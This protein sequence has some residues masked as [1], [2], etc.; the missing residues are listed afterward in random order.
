[1]EIQFSYSQ[2]HLVVIPL[3]QYLNALRFM[4]HIIILH[5]L[6]HCTTKRVLFTFYSFMFLKILSFHFVVSCFIYFFVYAYKTIIIIMKMS[7]MNPHNSMLEIIKNKIYFFSLL[8]SIWLNI[9]SSHKTLW[10]RATRKEL[11]CRSVLHKHR[12]ISCHKLDKFR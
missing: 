12:C 4:L 2:V 7:L 5:F 8:K 10:Y 9:I 3:W 6:K 11:E 1:M